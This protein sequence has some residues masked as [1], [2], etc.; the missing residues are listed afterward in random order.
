MRFDWVFAIGAFIQASKG[1]P[2][3]LLIVFVAFAV[4]FPCAF[5][6]ARVRMNGT[7][8]LSPIASAYVS[9]VRGTPPV[10]KVLLMYS[11][12]PLFLES[13]VRRLRLGFSVYD[14]N[15]IFYAFIIYGM[16]ASAV[17]SEIWKSSLSAV[18]AGQYEAAVSVGLSPF[19]AYVKVIIPQALSVGAAPFCSATLSVLK[20]TSIVFLM[21]IPD[22]T[23]RARLAAAIGYKYLEAYAIIFIIYLILCS[24]VEQAFKFAEHRLSRYRVIT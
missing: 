13:V 11:L 22:I 12:L 24:L 4:G 5:F 14:V 17:Y 10:A 1:I 21:T 9:F 7:P 3:T 20:S 2:V 15:P 19:S 18:E 6:I 16:N 23:G 8:I